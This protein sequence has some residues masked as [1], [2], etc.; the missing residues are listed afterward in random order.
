M[1][2]ST[3]NEVR[4]TEPSTIPEPGLAK[5]WGYRLV[6]FANR[7]LTRFDRRPGLV[8]EHRDDFYTR[9][10]LEHIERDI[11]T[12]F[13]MDRTGRIVDAGCGTGRLAVPLAQQG[14]AVTGIDYHPPSLE[15]ARQRADQAGVEL[16]LVA[17]NLLQALRRLPD[18]GTSAVLCMGV[19][20]T[21]PDYRE[22]LGEFA[23]ILRPGGL[24]IIDFKSRFFMLTTL[25]RQGKL[26]AAEQV[27]S[28]HEGLLQVA[29]APAYYHWFT[30][31]EAVT[32]ISELGLEVEAVEP[33]GRFFGDGYD[34]MAGVLDIDALTDPEDLEALYRIERLTVPRYPDMAK[35]IYVAARKEADGQRN[36]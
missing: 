33:I 30:A 17:A 2:K 7:I 35:F 11:S 9:I 21:C 24:L 28:E 22:I 10:Y 32:L 6:R 20:Y 8:P 26:S 34:G 3:E 29:L 14:F 15:T 31:D 27:A 23:R 16:D 19:L 18:A 4:R 25:L 12:A 1:N 13:G 5:R 36:G